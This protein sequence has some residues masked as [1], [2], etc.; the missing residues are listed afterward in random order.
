MNSVEIEI[1]DV[2]Y[3]CHGI[4]T[5]NHDYIETNVFEHVKC[6][7][8]IIVEHGIVLIPNKEKEEYDETR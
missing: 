8:L 7:T 4:I 2:C 6:P 1:I 5:T 3:L